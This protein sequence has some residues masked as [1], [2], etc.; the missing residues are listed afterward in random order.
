MR[1]F[2]SVNKVWADMP[3]AAK[4][5]LIRAVGDVRIHPQK[6]REARLHQVEVIMHESPRSS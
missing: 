2:E 3:L 5:D 1:R 4:R 6:G